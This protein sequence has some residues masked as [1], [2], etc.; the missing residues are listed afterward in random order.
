M[1]KEPHKSHKK[2]ALCVEC[3]E[4]RRIKGRKHLKKKAN[5]LVHGYFYGKKWFPE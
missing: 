2:D 4:E 5:K 1:K 3:V